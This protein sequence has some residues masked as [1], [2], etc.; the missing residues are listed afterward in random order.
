MY[1]DLCVFLLYCL[2]YVK[3]EAELLKL[4]NSNFTMSF[5]YHSCCY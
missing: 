1:S 5:I 3:F 2:K 4:F